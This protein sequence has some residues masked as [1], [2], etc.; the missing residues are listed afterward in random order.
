MARRGSSEARRSKPTRSL[1]N[2]A[3]ALLARRDHSRAELSR[4]LARYVD[5]VDGLSE[6]AHVLD[7]LDRNQLLSD[8][9][10]AASL[11]RIRSQRFGNAR[12]RHDLHRAGVTAGVSAAAL[13]SLSDS[14]AARARQ[15]WA[16]RFTALPTS[17]AERARQGRFLQSR[18]FSMD[19]ILQVLRGRADTD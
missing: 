18:G 2:R 12:I 8:E 15:I 19:T 10:F 1:L 5:P 3:V 16:R 4:K 7:D 11:A 17:A 14:E 6:I 9:R 13:A